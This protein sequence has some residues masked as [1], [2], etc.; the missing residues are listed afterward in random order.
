M[1]YDQCFF[2]FD[3]WDKNDKYVNFSFVKPWNINGDLIGLFIKAL[4]CH[5]IC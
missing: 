2:Y 5:P 3:G 4:H 1:K